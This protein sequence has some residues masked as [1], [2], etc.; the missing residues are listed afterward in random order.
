MGT[1]RRPSKRAARVARDR[2]KL[3]AAPPEATKSMPTL[4]SIVLNVR[5]LPGMTLSRRDQLHAHGAVAHLDDPRL[6]PIPAPGE[7]EA[8]LL[9][10]IGVDSLVKEIAG[11]AAA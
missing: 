10:G 2:R 7:R 11:R 4:T 1:G 9:R 8:V 3:T 6:R 5:S